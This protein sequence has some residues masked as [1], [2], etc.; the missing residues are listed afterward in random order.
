VFEVEPDDAAAEEKLA[1]P[2]IGARA[3]GGQSVDNGQV[4][5]NRS[6]VIAEHCI[7]VVERRRSQNESRR[8]AVD[9][10]FRQ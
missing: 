6:A 8:R 10:V 9:D 4:R 3:P 1:P 2:C 7:P 5:Q